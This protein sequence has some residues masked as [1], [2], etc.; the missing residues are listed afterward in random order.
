MAGTYP[1]ELLLHEW[2]HTFLLTAAS[3]GAPVIALDTPPPGT[4]RNPDL[5]W[6][7]WYATVL[8]RTCDALDALDLHS[9]MA[10]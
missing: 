9:S 7:D 8:A 1:G 4:F 2:L 3:I 10:R 6:A 5:S